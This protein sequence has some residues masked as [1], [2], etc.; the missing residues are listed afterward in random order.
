MTSTPVETIDVIV[1]EAEKIADDCVALVLERAGGGDL[2][3]WEPGAHTDVVMGGGLVRQYSLCGDPA[4]T[5]NWRIGVLREPNSRGGSIYLHDRVQAGSALIVQGPRNHFPLVTTEH[6]LFVAGGIGIT[7]ILT[8]V[9][10]AESA[11]AD[12]RLLYG[13]RRRE[14]MAFL[15]E[16]EG[17]GDRVMV[18]PEDKYGLLDLTGFLADASPDTAAYCCGPEPLIAAM[19]ETCEK[20]TFPLSLHVERFAPKPVVSTV[21]NEEFEVV[22]EASG[23]TVTVPADSTILAE[24]RKAGIEVLSS[25]TEGTCGTC[26]TDIIEGTPDHRDSVLTPEDR[27]TGESMMICVSRCIGKRLVLDL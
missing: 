27:K 15:D 1:R 8:M 24:V 23:I 17:Y 20:T 2:P 7:P 21:V 9:H 13:G 22:C 3:T 18:R 14:S 4:D 12:W 6:Y 5:S 26:E 10:A 19:E 11:G 16:L 25:C